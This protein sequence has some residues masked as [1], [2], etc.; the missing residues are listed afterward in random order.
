MENNLFNTEFAR[1]SKFDP[2]F[3]GN[4]SKKND[5]KFLAD[6]FKYFLDDKKST[7][8]LIP[9]LIHQI[10]LGDKKLPKNCIP[11]MKSWKNFNPDWEY[12]LWNEENIKELKINLAWQ[13]LIYLLF[14]DRV[15]IDESEI[16]KEIQYGEEYGSPEEQPDI[17]TKEIGG[18][19][20]WNL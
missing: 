12:K 3:V 5:W 6:Q 14:N 19:I 13:K 8:P 18:K 20:K 9:K 10:W 11:W 1:N 17:P 7:K 2:N 15:K 4:I 16:I